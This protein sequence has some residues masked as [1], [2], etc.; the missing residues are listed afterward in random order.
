MPHC[1]QSTP[2]IS[3]VLYY[4]SLY[5]EKMLKMGFT[6]KEIQESLSESRYDE[7]CATYMLLIRDTEVRA[8][9]VSSSRGGFEYPPISPRREGGEVE[10]PP[11]EGVG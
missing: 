1:I 8:C 5:I 3:N 6:Q 9:R 11:V 10:Y 2:L 7:V 4:C